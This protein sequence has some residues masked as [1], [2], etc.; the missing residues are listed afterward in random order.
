MTSASFV[1]RTTLGLLLAALLSG[2]AFAKQDGAYTLPDDITPI[3]AGAKGYSAKEA[4]NFRTSFSP[5][6]F[7]TA[8]NIGAYAASNMSEFLPMSV[9]PRDGQI[10]E[11]VVRENKAI[12]EVKYTSDLGELTVNEVLAD[13]R[14]RMKGMVVIHQG[15]IVFEQYPAMRDTDSHLWASATKTLVS[16]VV[17]QLESEGKVDLKAPISTYIPELKGSEWQDIPLAQ[18][19]H[20]NSGMDA[21]EKNVGVP[22]HPITQLYMMATGDTSLGKDRSFIDAALDAKKI[23][24]PGEM[25]EYSSINTFLLGL[26]A[27]NIIGLPMHDIISQQ[28][29]A[30]SGMEGDALLGLSP[31]GEAAPFG[32][33]SSRLRD[34]ARYG[35]L[36]TPSWNKVSGEPIV[37]ADYLEKTYA[38]IDMDSYNED[39]MSQRLLKN[40]GTECIG[41]SYQ[42][43]AVFCDG[44]LYKSGR[45]GQ[46]LYVS[47]E[48]DTVVVWYSSSYEN[49]LW[50]E[51]YSRAI[52]NS[53]YR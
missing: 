34:L 47:P 16:L 4:K 15:E 51:G 44:D 41:A 8:N 53:V 33:F 31:T 30:K 20:Q 25:F 14:S 22:G 28:V 7:Q 40:F 10:S 5:I 52:V 18:V 37:P 23:R 3:W 35:M 6:D 17:A 21:G 29:W 50:L 24:E 2:N 43:D 42:W 1:K 45:T 36:Y 32:I 26:V 49:R 13:E 39:Y 12:G 48:T 9:V 38:A 27:E 11:L 19:M 46:A